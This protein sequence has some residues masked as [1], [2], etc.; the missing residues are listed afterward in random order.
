MNDTEPLPQIALDLLASIPRRG[1][2]L[3]HHLFCT[4]RV[5]HAFRTKNQIIELLR[6]RTA[7]LA[8]KPGEI[9]RQVEC[10]GKVP[11]H[12]NKK[13]IVKASPAGLKLDQQKRANVITKT[14]AGL[15]NLWE[16]SPVRLEDNE[17]HTEEIIDVLFPNDP[18]L[19]CGR[20][21]SEFQTKLRSEWRG[22][23]SSYALIVPNTMTARSGKTKEGK[24]S[25]HALSITGA[26]RFLVIEQDKGSID[27][28]SAILLHLAEYAPLA[29]A[30]HS[31][32]KSIHGWFACQ[33]RTEDQQLYRFMSY[34][35]SLGADPQLWVRSQFTRM[36]DGRRENGNKQ[37]VF[38]FNPRVIK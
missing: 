3:N 22:E 14:R 31:S 7:G 20:S 34:A 6:A 15:V 33:D 29:L 36:P 10:S 23:L 5:L 37:T 21:H 18:L 8:I 13:N 35:I 28:Q 16:Y 26:R 19:C 32:G 17:S 9:E 4:A 2:G 30:V 11:W 25:A 38:F 24:K 1:E 27:D 12:P